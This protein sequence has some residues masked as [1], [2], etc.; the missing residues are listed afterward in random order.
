MGV[1]TGGS[2]GRKVSV[3]ICVYMYV[4]KH[5]LIENEMKWGFGRTFEFIF[6]FQ[7]LALVVDRIST[8]IHV[9][10]L[11]FYFFLRYIFLTEDFNSCTIYEHTDVFR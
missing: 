1:S 4:A 5:M 11:Y 3:C 7:F 2:K 10:F 9:A 6:L 8:A